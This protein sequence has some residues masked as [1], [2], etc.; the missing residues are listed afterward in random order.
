MKISGR[1][2]GPNHPPYIIAEI[3][4]NHNGDFNRAI[5]LI[6]VAKLSGADAVKLQCYTPDTMTIDCDGEGFTIKEGL[7]KDKKLYDLYREAHTPFEWMAAL[8]A[9]ARDLGITCFSS[10]FDHSSVELLEKLDCPAYKIASFEITDIPLIEHAARAGKPIIISTGAATPDDMCLAIMAARKAP[11]A[12]LHCVSDYPANQPRFDKL[13]DLRRIWGGA[14]GFSDHTLGIQAAVDSVEYGAQIIERHLKLDDKGSDVAFSSDGREFSVMVRE[15]RKSWDATQAKLSLRRSLYV[16]SDIMEG[17]I[18]TPFNVRSIRPGLGMHPLYTNHIM[19]KRA[20]KDIRRGTPLA[21]EHLN[22]AD[23]CASVQG[24]P[25]SL[26]EAASGKN[27]G[28]EHQP[29]E[30]TDLGKT[31]SIH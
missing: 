4:G 24:C 7:W 31:R 10:V 1:L 2:I 5:M 20:S 25:P 28:G 15:I 9:Y 29:Q 30:N 11:T 16:V 12:L 21:W 14:V 22:A 13:S 27:A 18:F 19:G 17:S 23:Q 3:S 26:M 8:F 6:R